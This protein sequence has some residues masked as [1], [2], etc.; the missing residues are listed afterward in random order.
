LATANAG[1]SLANYAGLADALQAVA[2]PNEEVFAS[3]LDFQRDQAR[4]ANTIAALKDRAGAQVSVAQMTVDAINASITAIDNASAAELAA[5]D[6]QHAEDVARLDGIL[7]AAQAQIDAM[8]GVNTSV[9][10]VAAALQSFNGAA[11]VAKMDPIISATPRI[12][13]AYQT[14]L[15]RNADAS[16]VDYW[17]NQVA[18]GMTATQAVSAIGNSREAQIADLYRTV[19]GREPDAAGLKYQSDSGLSVEQIKA[20]ILSSDEYRSLPRFALGGDHL[21]GFAIAGEHGPEL[22]NTG[23]SR[24]FNASDT[25][26]ILNGGGN[27]E[28][29]AEVRK[30]RE[31]VALLRASSDKAAA[32]ASAQE[33][34]FRRISPDGNSINVTVAA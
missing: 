5:L 23:P 26:R 13:S 21:G 17:R 6:R 20:N 27:A 3:V 14:A 28:L 2:K 30:L 31:E 15:G 4:T 19:L 29:A 33:R 32:S 11:S 16:E 24:I 8:N 12:T 18:G 1:G 22:I 25:A 9:L 34:F 10:T 7:S